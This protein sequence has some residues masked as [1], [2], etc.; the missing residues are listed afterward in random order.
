MTEIQICDHCF[1][2]Q[3]DPIAGVWGCILPVIVGRQA[4]DTCMNWLCAVCGKPISVNVFDG[5]KPE[6]RPVDHSRCWPENQ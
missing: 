3:K 2:F 4:N 1:N 5:G 6:S